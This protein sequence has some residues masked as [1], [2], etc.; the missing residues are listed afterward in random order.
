MPYSLNE[1]FISSRIRLLMYT[2]NQLDAM[3]GIQRIVV[4][5]SQHPDARP[6]IQRD[7]CLPQSR[8]RVITAIIKA[9]DIAEGSLNF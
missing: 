8:N 9:K 2:V 4:L 5:V 3:E 7:R 1:L 6:S